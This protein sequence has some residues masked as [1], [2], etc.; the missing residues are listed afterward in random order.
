MLNYTKN[1]WEETFFIHLA[2]SLGLKTN[3]IPFEL[4]AKSIRLKYLN[5]KP[6]DIFRTEAILFGQAGFLED[7]LK[8]EYQEQLKKEFDYHRKK[9]N[10]HPIDKHL[11]KFL[12]LR[13][14]NFPTIR[15][16]QLSSLLS[17]HSHL[18]S[19]TFDSS[20]PEDLFPIYTADVSEYW[21]N[22]FTFG[23]PSN[24]TIKEMGRGT[25]HSLIINTIVPL[26]FVYGETKN[27]N[28]L[29]EKAVEYL[30]HIPP[31]NN[32]VIRMWKKLNFTPKA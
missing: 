10:L 19:K 11:W 1:N 21:K 27:R 12:R 7:K 16:A 4:L 5:A 17:R 18:L 25:I 31:E 22:H 2:R 26:M 13:P 30:E 28:E 9:Y 24:E 23:N 32:H 20:Q 3:A 14:L 15:I 8:D 6:G 29:K